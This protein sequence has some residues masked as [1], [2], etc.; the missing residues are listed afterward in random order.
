M[1]LRRRVADV[2]TALITHP[3]CLEHDTGPY[4]PETS[5]R[6]RAV[7]AALE[8][9]E[10]SDLLRESAP[11]ATVEQLSRVHPRSYV[12]GILSIRPELG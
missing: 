12:E 2:T 3:A 5:E 4:H 8:T 7:L 11:M 10:F 1:I 9:P 6:L